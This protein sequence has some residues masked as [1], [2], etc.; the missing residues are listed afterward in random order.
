MS[1]DDVAV[2]VFIAAGLVAVAWY[3]RQLVVE[4]DPRLNPLRWSPLGWANLVALAIGIVAAIRLSDDDFW[5][6]WLVVFLPL[7]VVSVVLESAAGHAITAARLGFSSGGHSV[8]MSVDP[9]GWSSAVWVNLIYV[10]FGLLAILLLDGL[11][12]W[13]VFLLL[14]VTK[15]LVQRRWSRAST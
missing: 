11:A 15:T 4:R 13:L 3:A 14:L 10:V 12:F 7:Q 9:R 1:A 2:S 5:M 8:H 6:V